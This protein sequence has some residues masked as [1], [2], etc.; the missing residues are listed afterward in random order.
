MA[1]ERRSKKATKSK[2]DPD[3]E[4]RTVTFDINVETRA[5]GKKS[6]KG[7]AAVF[8][9]ETVVGDWFREK[10]LPGA[11]IDTIIEDDQRALWN[12]DPNYVLGRKNN[13]TL[14]LSEDKRGLA[15][16]I[17]PPDTQL[18][19]DLVIAP[20]ERGDV[21]KM[22]FSF[23]VTKL[24]DGSR[25]EEWQS[26]GEDGLLD[27]RII[28]KCRVIDIS[29]VTFAQY[30]GTD[31]A[32]RSHTE[33]RSAKPIQSPLS[34]EPAQELPEPPDTGLYTIELKRKSLE[35]KMKEE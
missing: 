30:T 29:P 10:I 4:S 20:I 6:L 25:G 34:P 17:S 22:S 28:K 32:L 8:N 27:L 35:L 9:E 2:I 16:D 23:R 13:D 1:T 11:F 18:I 15:I 26:G 19:R 5:D 7:H 21:D 31:I 33:W 12:H 24:A 14:S 3:I